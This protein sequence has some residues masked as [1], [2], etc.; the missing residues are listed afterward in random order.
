MEQIN[1]YKRLTHKFNLGWSYED[2][3]EAAALVK[4][5]PAKWVASTDDSSVFIERLIAPS[6]LRKTDLTRA[7]ASTLTHSGCRHEHDCCGCPSYHATVRRVSA[8]EY[9]AK[10][11]VTYNY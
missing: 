11:N 8:R 4:V 9:V 3:W 10:V 5:L 6:S 7:I 2:E 1:I